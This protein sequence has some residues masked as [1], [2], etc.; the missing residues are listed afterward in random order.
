VHAN[1]AQRRQGQHRSPLLRVG[2]NQQVSTVA[3]AKR[4]FREADDEVPTVFVS[5]VRQS[6]QRGVHVLTSEGER[7]ADH[8]DVPVLPVVAVWWVEVAE[9]ACNRSGLGR[10]S[11]KAD[12][13]RLHPS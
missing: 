1:P 11:D 7:L 3:V 6:G 8:L 5:M 9:P 13:N 10:V 2:L 4:K 12:A